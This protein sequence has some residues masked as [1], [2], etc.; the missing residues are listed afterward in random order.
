MTDAVFLDR[1]GVIN[2][3]AFFP[4]LG[5][6]DSPLNPSQFRLIPG[7]AEAIRN[8]NSL[9][10]KVI[11]VS[12][13]PAIAKGKMSE[14]LFDKIR[15]KMKTLLEKKGAHVDA[16]YYCFHHPHAKRQK[17]KA[18]CDCRKPKPG[19]ILQAKQDFGLDTSKCYMIGDGLL[20]IKAGHAVGCKCILIGELKCDLCR[21]MEAMQVKPDLIAPSLLA[22]SKI[23]EGE[24]SEKWRYSLT[25]QA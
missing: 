1:D 5:I 14:E 22:A 11:I 9:G 21:R 20:D 24:L 23:I 18:V 6:I 10:L 15:S 8:F 17:F 16:E 2:R 7:A 4:E 12:N 3:L 13:Q 25:Q 19:L